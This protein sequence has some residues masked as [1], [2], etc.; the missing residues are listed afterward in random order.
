MYIGSVSGS[1]R[2]PQQAMMS[3]C[4]PSP[5]NSSPSVD[6]ANRNGPSATPPNSLSLRSSHNQLLSSDVIKQGQTTPPK[7]RKK[8]ALTSIQS[9]MGLGEGVTPP[10]SSSGTGDNP[11]LAKNGANQ[12]RKAADHNKNTTEEDEDGNTADQSELNIDDELR[13][14]EELSFDSESN[15]DD[16]QKDFDP[17]NELVN[18]EVNESNDDVT[19]EEEREEN[20][21]DLI[22]LAE[23]TEIIPEKISHENLKTK[24]YLESCLDGLESK[25]PPDSKDEDIIKP[26]LEKEMNPCPSSPRKKH[27]PEDTPLLS[28]RSS[29]SS[30]SPETKKDRPRT[31]AKTD[32]ALNRIQNLPHSDE[33]SSWTTLS[34]DSASL[35]SPEESAVHQTSLSQ[36]QCQSVSL[37]T[38]RKTSQLCFPLSSHV[39]LSSR[40]CSVM[41]LGKDYMLAIVIVNYDD[42]WGEQSFQTDPDLPPGWKMMTDMAGI[43]YWHIP[44]GTTQWERPAPCHPVPSGPSQ[45]SRKH[46]L[47]SL[48]PSPTPDHESYADVF[49]GASSRSGSTTSDSSS[50]PAPVQLSSCLEP[51]P[52]LSSNS[53]SSS[54]G[55]E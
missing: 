1:S 28:V 26:L 45:A 55:N 52:A 14:I 31:G 41:M 49:F 22:I 39:I 38:E 34:Q 53:S 13:N 42:I 37:D 5:P 18:E 17:N 35:G 19:N 50:D 33:E 6:V 29:S 8:Y 16:L 25:E 44:T 2:K 27:T 40:C 7:C 15:V 24:S 30:S 47:G 48:S 36:T 11:K 10:P 46:S 32:R 51:T 12:L 21:E 20:C 43:Y 9:A 23:K 3:V 4:V 54:D